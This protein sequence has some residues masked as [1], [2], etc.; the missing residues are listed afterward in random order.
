MHLALRFRFGFDD[1]D[2]E[3][4]VYVELRDPEENVRWGMQGRLRARQIPA[5]RFHH[6][7]QIIRLTGVQFPGPD[8]YHFIIRGETIAE[9]KV[10]FQVLQIEDTPAT[11]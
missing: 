7:N 11:P 10:P 3:H 6:L 9:T 2:K 8:D 4:T 1:S 5:G